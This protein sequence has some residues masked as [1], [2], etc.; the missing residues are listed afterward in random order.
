MTTSE[1]EVTNQKPH[2]AQVHLRAAGPQDAAFLYRV[3]ASTRADEMVAVNWSETEKSAFLRMQFDAQRRYYEAQFPDAAFQVIF[4]KD[5]PI[6][7][8]YV[9]RR[10]DEIRLIDIALLP[11]CRGTG[12]GSRLMQDILDEAAAAGKCVRI[13]VEQFNPARRLY[14]RLGF[15]EIKQQGIYLLMEWTPDCSRIKPSDQ[16]A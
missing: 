8:L 15:R 6:G 9:D 13:H 7:R 16:A 2:A 5:K 1:Y 12:I 14:D 10:D 4:A 3:Y 11:E